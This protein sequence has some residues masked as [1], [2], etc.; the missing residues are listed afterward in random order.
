MKSSHIILFSF[1]LLA[2]S[3]YAQDKSFSSFD[4]Q[5]PA[6][7]TADA[8]HPS[9]LTT[10]LRLNEVNAKALRNFAREFKDAADAKWFEVNN[11]YVAY[12]QQ[13]GAKVR[14]YYTKKGNPECTAR[15]YT[16]AAL[17]REIR[18]LVKSKFYDYGIYCITEISTN[19]G[20]V[21][22]IKLEGK[23]SWKTL[24][25]AANEVEVRDEYLKGGTF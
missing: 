19:E 7:I 13:N 10:Q 3:V 11:G 24:R 5:T 9:A 2:S 18:H 21:Y 25:V 14:A 16:E 4:G 12:F 17:P 22:F 6:E 23:D 1:L 8:G 15:D 20:S